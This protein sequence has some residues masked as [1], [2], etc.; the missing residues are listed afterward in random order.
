MNKEINLIVLFIFSPILSLYKSVTNFKIKQHRKY[1]VFLGILYGIT[2]IP[3]KDSD[4]DRYGKDYESMDYSIKKYTEDVLNIYSEQATFPDIYIYTVFLIGKTFTNNVKF[5]RFLTATIYFVIFVHLMSTIYDFNKGKRLK[6]ESVLYMTAIVFITSLAAGINHIRFPL[7][8]IIFAFSALKYLETS[9]IKYILLSSIAVFVHFALLYLII[10]LVFYSIIK[11]DKRPVFLIIVLMI[12]VLFYSVFTNL[13]VTNT[14]NI[15]GAFEKR[16][17]G[18]M[19]ET[20]IETREEHFNSWN[21][22]I[23]INQYFRFTMPILTVVVLMLY[24]NRIYF[25]I[26]ANKLLYFLIILIIAYVTSGEIVDKI[27]NR[28]IAAAT[29]FNY[30]L[31]FYLTTIN[32][33]NKILKYTS[34]LYTPFVILN[35]LITLRGDLYTVNP[36][37][38]FISPFISIFIDTK[39]SIQQLLLGGI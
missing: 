22:Y 8:F 2:F 15:G 1:I 3:I 39:I 16:I 17:T 11:F 25:N 14:L 7:A 6:I 37:S 12:F 33:K 19:G 29:F 36:F 26:F 4:G 10:Y 28:Y 20:F 24:K 31:L 30:I 38:L 34:Y 27:S 9:N 23:I 32:N 5:F 18:Y 13:L 35:V 21:W